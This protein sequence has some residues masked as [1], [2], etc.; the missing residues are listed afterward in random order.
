MEAWLTERMSIRKVSEFSAPMLEINV[1]SDQIYFLSR[2][3]FHLQV[4][5]R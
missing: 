4:A 1:R 5:T 2:S 3:T